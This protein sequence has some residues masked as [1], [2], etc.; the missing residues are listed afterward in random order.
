MSTDLSDYT[1]VIQ[2]LASANFALSF[3]PVLDFSF[4][5]NFRKKYCDNL[6]KITTDLQA[7]KLHLVN[8]TTEI[9]KLESRKGEDTRKYSGI[10]LSFFIAT[11]VVLFIADGEISIVRNTVWVFWAEMIVA[12]AGLIFWLFLI[13]LSYVGLMTNTVFVNKIKF[14]IHHAVLK[15]T[16]TEGCIDQIMEKLNAYLGYSYI[17]RLLYKLRYDKTLLFEIR[18]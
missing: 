15:G 8:V 4:L 2:F 11:F 17:K 7:E 12:L 18:A 14:Q 10:F 1:S 5:G 16:L 13:M 9:N 3:G 6:K